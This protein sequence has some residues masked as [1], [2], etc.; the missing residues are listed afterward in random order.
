[1]VTGNSSPVRVMLVYDYFDPATQAGGPI[2]SCVNLVKFLDSDFEFFVFTTNR[3][4]DGSKL[5]VP[6]D[7]WLS[8][9]GNSRVMYADKR[10]TLWGFYESLK[11]A[12][13]TVLYINGIYSVVATLIPLLIGWFKGC[14]LKLVIAPRGML[15]KEALGH[16]Y[17][18]KKIYI[19]FLK[20]ILC[21]N[22]TWHVTSKQEEQDLRA[23]LPKLQSKDIVK[24]GNIPRTDIHFIRKTK[25]SNPF[26]LVTIAVISPMKNLINVIRALGKVGIEV[27]YHLFG[28]IKDDKYW[29][30]CKRI[31]ELLP[32]NVWFEYR[33]IADRNEIP[34]LL[35]SYD[36]YVQPSQSEN[37]G[38]SLFEAMMAGLPLITSPNT[39]WKNLSHE[40]AGLNVV[41]EDEDQIAD[42][43]RTLNNLPQGE[44]EQWRRNARSIAEGYLEN[45]HFRNDY[46]S[47][48]G[49]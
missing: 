15:Q 22:I 48:F 16:K 43:I 33:G 11:V 7:Q 38:H 14:N 49:T 2:S 35:A 21:G 1:M 34:E 9:V 36:V 6:S 41:G 19:S 4:L 27:S 12:R 5:P 31:I 42:A 24:I 37:F 32:P 46:K 18:K 26:R 29:Q 20:A 3:E 8:Y 13:P 17:L 40:K 23:A 30:E 47:L 44:F 39:P 45:S 10:W 28:P 25:R